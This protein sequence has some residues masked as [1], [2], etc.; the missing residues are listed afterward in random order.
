MSLLPPKPPADSVAPTAE[1]AAVVFDALPNWPADSACLAIAGLPARIGYANA[2]ALA[3]F[4]VKDIAAFDTRLLTGA[5]PSARRLRHLAATL[6]IGDAPRLERMLF[7]VGRRRISVNLRCARVAGSAGAPCLLVS[8]PA[9]GD[10]SAESAGPAAAQDAARQD[11]SVPTAPQEPQPKTRFLWALDE[12][13]RFGDAHPALIAAVGTNAP[14]PG[15]TAAV[16]LRRT[17][18]EPSDKFADILAKRETFSDFTVHW[19]LAGV[20]RQRRITLSAAPLFDRSRCFAGYRGFGVLGE[21]FA[22]PNPRGVGLAPAQ[23]D[24]A[25]GEKEATSPEAGHDGHPVEASASIEAA[26]LAQDNFAPSPG[27]EVVTST[28]APPAE[29]VA[30]AQDD[31]ARFEDGPVATG[32]AGETG[33]QVESPT[34]DSSPPGA[35]RADEAHPETAADDHPEGLPAAEVQGEAEA[36]SG[37]RPTDDVVS[38]VAGVHSAA[39]ERSAEIY[40]LRQASAAA[41]PAKVVPIRPGALDALSPRDPPQATPGESVELSKN[42]REAFRE[43]ARALVGRPHASNDDRAAESD[44]VNPVADARD[45]LDLVFA[46]PFGPTVA[47][48]SELTA[49]G[50]ADDESVERNARA[51]LDRLP[52]GALVARDARALYV[53]QTLLDLLGYRDFAHFQAADGLAAMFR[54]RDPQSIAP[55]TGALP[56]VR[57]DGQ[58]L[59]VDGH[60]QAIVWDGAP[61][62]LFAFRRSPEAELRTT[63]RALEREAPIRNPANDLQTMLDYAID[64]AVML[65][66]T[67]R[68]LSLN[69]P[70]ERL[71]GYDEKEIAGE[72]A[73][74]LLAPQSHPE[75][76]A[77][78]ESLSRAGKPDL[79]GRPLQVV[80]R[81]R[82]GGPLA[83]ALTLA[84][85]GPTDAPRYCALFRD[86]SREREAERRLTA[87]RDAAQAASAA[88]TDFLAQVSHE[89]RTPLHAILGFAEVMME[90]RFGPIGNERYK[91][92]LKDIHA[93]GKHVKSLA[94]DLLDLSKIEAGKLELDFAPVDANNLIRE[95]VSLMQ[96][97]AARERII[98]RVS[99]YERLP[100][101]MVDERSLKQIMLNLM[102]N[103][104]KFNEPGG[105]VIISTAVDASGQAMIRV[106]D[107]GVGMSENEVGL[108]LEPFSQVGKASRKGGAGLGLPLTK[109]LVEANKAELSIK[110]RR[111]QGTLI[112]IAFPN[113][114]A[115]Q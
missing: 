22:A 69:Q 52:I 99:L 84:R 93:S 21:E 41:T 13:E 68:I 89:I 6:P 2:A 7:F 97:Q 38:H 18:L 28:I 8:T 108:A 106:R 37:A 47:R 75:A 100:R 76:T 90:E 107:T 50:G 36:Q 78:L 79:P 24:E 77:K 11:E 102:S 12:E 57:A 3:L 105:Q 45:M 34:E 1:H 66:S 5:G 16:L 19:P 10:A 31:I 32:R 25:L 48:E 23:E 15:E 65:D 67:G 35:D 58:S 30:R 80:G 40:V 63:P 86:L 44:A 73:L 87:A 17:G 96:P 61:A 49:P 27:S 112:E 20:D 46:A 26:G 54:D 55:E 56:I 60:A 59:A 94:D 42:E 109:A 98:M 29:P 115:A 64:G 33:A 88:K 110:S 104:V 101:V 70:A 114:Q 111:E 39:S 9:P 71:F 14:R 51:I 81:D 85:I 91:D 92:Y 82:S 95:C 103:A 62:T 72:S 83:L 43:I 74:M 113:V 4:G 53:N